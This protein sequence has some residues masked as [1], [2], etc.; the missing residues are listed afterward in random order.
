MPATSAN[1]GPGFDCLGLA[2][3]LCDT[4]VGEVLPSGLEVLVEGEGADE[5]PLD[6]RHL[7]VRAMRAL[8]A[9]LGEQP[10]G[11][12][13]TCR[14]R[15]PHSRGLGSSSAAIVGGLVLARGLVV[16][17]DQRVDDTELLHLAN[18]LEGHPDNVAPA[19]LGGLVVSGQ[20]DD[21]VWAQRVPLDPRVA[22]VVLVPPHGV[23]T[24]VARGL[25]PAQVPHAEAAA[26][27]GRAAL[28]VAALAGEP[29]LLL[30]G[31]E[32]FLHQRQREPAMPE[33][34][35]LV[36]RLRAAGTPAVISGAGPTVLAFVVD[37]VPGQS[38]VDDLLAQAPDGWR[39]LFQRPGGA[40]ARVLH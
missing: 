14:N 26:N 35:A 8:W 25:L 16:D 13:L 1:L 23:R 33:S 28:L 19:L 4:L 9:T 38:A 36:E 30:R 39:A 11:L 2:L 5:V 7:V 3:E 10:P 34:W 20:A 18:E 6:D 37:S 12:R 22:A 29:S 27:T 15:L 32:D 24:D 17:G 40:G 31:T 21:D